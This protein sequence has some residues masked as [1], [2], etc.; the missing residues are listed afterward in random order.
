MNPSL[1]SLAARA[2]SRSAP[3]AARAGRRDP[4]RCGRTADVDARRMNFATIAAGFAWRLAPKR[5][6]LSTGIRPS[7]ATQK[8][9]AFPV[10]FEIPGYYNGKDTRSLIWRRSSL[11]CYPL[12]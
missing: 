5:A 6:I 3:L 12:I 7:L 9:V 11:R 8:Q 10:P 4:R 2:V 1:A